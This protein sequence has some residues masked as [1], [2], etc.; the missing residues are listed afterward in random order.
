M[1]SQLYI[2]PIVKADNGIS[3]ALNINLQML[4][5]EQNYE[6]EQTLQ[7]VLVIEEF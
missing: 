3:G 6:F 4:A 7:N 1:L 5:D 2:R